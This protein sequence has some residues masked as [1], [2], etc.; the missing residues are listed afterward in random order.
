MYPAPYVPHDVWYRRAL[1]REQVLHLLLPRR[2]TLLA[3][4]GAGP[5]LRRGLRRQRGA[6]HC[7]GHIRRRTD[8]EPLRG[9][10]EVTPEGEPGEEVGGGVVVVVHD[11]PAAHARTLR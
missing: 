1:A 7:D 3:L 6:L 2:A 8:P 9:G 10:S 11:E 5:L 4:Y